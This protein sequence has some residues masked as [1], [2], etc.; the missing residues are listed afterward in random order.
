MP[1]IHLTTVIHAPL[2]RVF[3]LSRSIT[4]HKR[5]MEHTKEEA[6]KGR[7]SGLIEYN[8]TVTWQARHLGRLREMTIKI[9][10]MQPWQYFCDEMTDGPFRSFRHEHYFKEIGN[11]TIAID[12]LNFSTPYGPFGRWFNRLYLLRYMTNLLQLRNQTVKEFAESEKWRVV[13][14]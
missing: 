13:L 10:A 9:V 2:E 12:I 6:V 14:D 3:D 1:T 7:T 11:G 5:S 4:L 8:E